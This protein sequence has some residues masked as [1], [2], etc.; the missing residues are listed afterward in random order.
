MKKIIFTFVALS[1][2]CSMPLFAEGD[3]ADETMS[4]EPG[5]TENA[6]S[7]TPPE[8]HE[9][10]PMPLAPEAEQP[11]K[12]MRGK[13]PMKGM[14]MM[15]PMMGGKS[16]MI[17]SADG[18]VIVLMGNKLMKYDAN[19]DLVKEVELK[20][21]MMGGKNRPMKEK[22]EKEQAESPAVKAEPT[23]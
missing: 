2:V 22:T 12:E 3:S 8:I 16:S 6:L 13:R 11:M 5:A 10:D 19:L 23:V 9:Q 15:C 17:A 21:P 7:F 4:Q 14:G 1:L 20:M 18:G